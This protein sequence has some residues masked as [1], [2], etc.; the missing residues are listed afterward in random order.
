LTKNLPG[1]VYGKNEL[2]L[3]RKHLIEGIDASLKRMQLE[4]V[5]VVYAHRFDPSTPIL[6]IVQAFTQLIRDG[7][8]FYWGTSMWP[9]VRILE[10]YWIAKVNKLIPPVVEQPLYNMFSRQYVE[11]EYLPL[12]EDPYNIG[13]TVWCPLDSGILTGKY[14]EGIPKDSRLGSDRLAVWFQGAFDRTIEEKRAKLRKLQKICEQLKC[15]LAELALAW[16]LKNK[17]VSVCLVG[18][19]RAEQLESNIKAL[20]VAKKLDKET[21][22]ELEKILENKPVRDASMWGTWGRV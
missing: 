21:M 16:I 10:A 5:D 1:N 11:A 17:D 7:K 6:E 3:S 9:A 22:A 15:E 4:Y 13:T 8:A 12:F 14:L 2:G 18:A 19:S 20:D